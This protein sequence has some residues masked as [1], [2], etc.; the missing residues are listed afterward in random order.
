MADFFAI[1]A[2]YDVIGM[3]GVSLYLGSYAA[4][5]TGFLRGQGYL[6]PAINMAAA[7]CVL[8]S[9]LSN[10]NLSSAIIQISWIII[11]IVGIFRMY[12]IQSRL[13]F[14]DNEL[15][16]M[17]DVLAGLP[18]ERAR[19]LLNT[20]IWMTAKP[21]TILTREGE[22]LDHFCYLASGCAD[23]VVNGQRIATTHS[24]TVIG[25]VTYLSGEPATATVQVS[26]QMHL[27]RFEAD[28]LRDFLKKNEDIRNI[29]EQN[30]ANQLRTKLIATSLFSGKAVTGV[31]AKNAVT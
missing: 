31:K 24:G 30:L 12:Y 21:E 16:F 5:Q 17:G 27:L 9:L 20:G 7:A 4:L 28:K 29:M 23:I 22:R 25:D 26:K 6:Y 2:L 13:N 18:R 14:S 11:S 10:F 3:I 15:L 19:V 1:P 8:I